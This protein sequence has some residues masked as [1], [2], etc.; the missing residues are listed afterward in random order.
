[1]VVFGSINKDLEA[2]TPCLPSRCK[3]ITGKVNQIF[4]RGK[5]ANQAVARAQLG[6]ENI[7]GRADWWRVFS[8]NTKA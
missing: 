6:G 4:A 3:T 2:R 5:G 1:M 8:K 7:I